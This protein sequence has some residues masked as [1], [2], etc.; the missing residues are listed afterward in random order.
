MSPTGRWMLNRDDNP[1]YPTI[2]LFRQSA[3]GDWDGV[4][5]RVVETLRLTA[6]K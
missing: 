3:R 5:R 4:I 2:R 1:W 6:K